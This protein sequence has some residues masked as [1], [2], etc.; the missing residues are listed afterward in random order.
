MK[1]NKLQKH[2]NQLLEEARTIKEINL[3]EKQFNEK[4]DIEFR[5][6]TNH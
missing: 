2:F 6:K 3:P 1:I 5:R 4:T